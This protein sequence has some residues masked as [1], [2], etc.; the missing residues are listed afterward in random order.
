MKSVAVLPF[1]RIIV[2]SLCAVVLGD[3]AT[4]GDWPSWRG[5]GRDDISTETGLLKSWP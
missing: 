1:F 4:A 5:P 3:L 2:F